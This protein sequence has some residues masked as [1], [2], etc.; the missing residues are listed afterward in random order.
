MRA[1]AASY[2][3]DVAG[4]V[5]LD[6]A[7]P[8]QWT[9]TPAGRAQYANDSRIYGM[10]RVLARL[11]V[12][13]ILPNPLTI[14]PAGLAPQQAAEWQA[15]YNT[16]QFWDASETESRAIPARMAQVRSAAALAPGMPVLVVSAGEHIRAD[17][18]WATF[19]HELA[20]I[21]RSS[22]QVV[23]AG[24]THESLWAESQG[25]Q[26]SVAAILTLTR[27]SLSNRSKNP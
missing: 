6:S 22:R 16:T 1:H 10:A 27:Q 13:R 14:P 4:L 8:D 19:Q 17:A 5:L 21:A 3:D 9:R 25:A 20:A 23:I 7:H 26:A 12:L 2:A 11:G 18:T 15:I 24:A